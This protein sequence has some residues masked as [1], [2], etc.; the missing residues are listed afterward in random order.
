L[1]VKLVVFALRQNSNGDPSLRVLED[2]G[3]PARSRP[4]AISQWD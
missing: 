4:A 1:I 3:C 2:F